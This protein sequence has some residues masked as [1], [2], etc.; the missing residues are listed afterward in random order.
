MLQWVCVGGEESGQTQVDY[1][2]AEEMIV[3]NHPIDLHYYTKSIEGWPKIVFEVRSFS[4]F[5][6]I[7]FVLP[8]FTFPWNEQQHKPLHTHTHTHTPKGLAFGPVRREEPQ[9]LQFL[10]CADVTRLARD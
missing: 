5:F 9:R 7:V 4:V 2:A 8:C 10:Q 1:P 6:A 3:W